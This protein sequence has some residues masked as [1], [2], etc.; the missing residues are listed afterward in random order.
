MAPAAAAKR[1]TGKLPGKWKETK[2]EIF[3][4]KILIRLGN[5]Q[6]KGCSFPLK[7][8]GTENIC[9]LLMMMFYNILKIKW[10]IHKFKNC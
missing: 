10:Y 5:L 9:K 1:K 3:E 6:E 4:E 2:S 8:K 7:Q